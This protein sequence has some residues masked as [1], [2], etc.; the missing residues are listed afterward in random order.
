MK[1]VDDEN[2][3]NLFELES[4]R[5]FPSSEFQSFCQIFKFICMISSKQFD[6]A[7]K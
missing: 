7:F 6:F 4:E 5:I 3:D 1:F 2:V